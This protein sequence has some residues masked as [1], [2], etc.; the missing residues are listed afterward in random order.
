MVDS[1][2][3]VSRRAADG[4]YASILAEARTSPGARRVVRGAITLPGEPHSP[5][6]PPAAPDDAGLGAA[7]GPVKETG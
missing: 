4:H 6:R 5:R 3:R 2:V 7:S 1:L